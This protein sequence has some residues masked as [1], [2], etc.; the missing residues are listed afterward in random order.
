MLG[1]FSVNYSRERVYSSGGFLEK[2]SV[3]IALDKK[4]GSQRGRVE[5][6]SVMVCLFLNIKRV[7]IRTG[8][9]NRFAC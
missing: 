4:I 3:R 8:S 7:G 9:H 6:L 1:P 2:H 5:S